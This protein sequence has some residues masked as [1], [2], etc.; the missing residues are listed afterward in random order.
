MLHMN[1]ALYGAKADI[2]VP[3]CSNLKTTHLSITQK[4]TMNKYFYANR[5]NK[6]LKINN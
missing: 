1:K 3:I 5:V 4:N 2:L 6:L